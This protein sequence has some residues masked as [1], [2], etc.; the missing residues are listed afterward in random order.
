[1]SAVMALYIPVQYFVKPFPLSPN[2][3]QVHPDLPLV[4]ASG[5]TFL[6]M[7]HEQPPETVGRLYYLTDRAHALQYAHATIFEGLPAI[8]QH[9]PIRGHVEP[10]R[11]FVRANRRFLVIG[12]MD[13]AEDW[14]LRYL[15]SIHA[16]L[17]FAGEFPSQSK[18]SQL[19]IVE[20]PSQ[21]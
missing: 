2:F 18:D 13:Y 9:F 16:K 8:K 1:M 14:L 6:E 17:E 12:T 15:L 4:A 20:M 11:D 10:F 5:L 19:F 7:D 3:A 21:N